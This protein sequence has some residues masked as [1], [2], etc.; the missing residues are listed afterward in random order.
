[1]RVGA[2][3]FHSRNRV[4]F[5]GDNCAA[6]AYPDADPW[7]RRR[8]AR[9]G[10]DAPGETQA[11]T[12]AGFAPQRGIGEV[13]RDNEGK[14]IRRC[15]GA[16]PDRDLKGDGE[17]VNGV[18]GVEVIEDQRAVLAGDAFGYLKAAGIADAIDQLQVSARAVVVG[19]RAR[20]QRAAI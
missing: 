18:A 17:T 13:G 9:T 6:S 10:V 15:R 11:A 14:S 3:G 7:V 20:R 12:R 4:S 2:A 1:A 19:V 8:L 5:I 16:T